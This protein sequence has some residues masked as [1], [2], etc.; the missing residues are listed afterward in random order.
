MPEYCA[1]PGFSAPTSLQVTRC[2]KA[3]RSEPVISNSPM[4]DTSNTPTSSRTARCSLLIPVGYVTGISKPAKGTILAPRATWTSCRGVRLRSR[5]SLVARLTPGR[6]PGVS[7][8]HQGREE[9]FLHVEPV[10]RFVPHTRLR[11]VDHVRRNL[12]TAVSRQAVQEDGLRIRELHQLRVDRESLEGVAPRFGLG[13]LPHRS[14]HVG[15]HDVGVLYGLLWN[16][17]DHHTPTLRRRL[18]LGAVGLEPLRARE[19]QLEAE[20][21]GGLEPGID[22]KSVV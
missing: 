1:W 2:T 17:R 11:A 5:S 22:R 20:H 19:P 14:P 13:L 7:R 4:C 10:L 21:G 6:R 18:V 3:L 16:L 9:R 15:V 8:S 12:F